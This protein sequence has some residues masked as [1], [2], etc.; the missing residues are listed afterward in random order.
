MLVLRQR[1]REPLL[2]GPELVE[3]LAHLPAAAGEHHLDGIF[4][5]ARLEWRDLEEERPI[6]SEEALMPRMMPVDRFEDDL[7]VAR[8]IEDD[9]GTLPVLRHT[10]QH[11]TRYV[12]RQQIPHQRLARSR[13]DDCAVTEN[14]RQRIR[15]LL[16]DRPGKVVAA[17]GREDDLH[18]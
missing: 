6:G 17:P 18:P 9:G 16:E 10:L 2:A 8:T 4:S 13:L 11:C 3:Q 7:A 12:A 1:H 14:E 15:E 5:E